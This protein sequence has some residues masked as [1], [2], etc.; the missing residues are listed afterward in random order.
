[1][2]SLRSAIF[3]ALGALFFS[4]T[5]LS[6][7]Y[8]YSSLSRN[9]FEAQEL[10]SISVFHLSCFDSLH[11]VSERLSVKLLIESWWHK[12]ATAMQ[13]T[14]NR[15]GTFL[16]FFS[17]PAT[18]PIRQ[19]FTRYSVL[20]PR[21]RKWGIMNRK[22]DSKKSIMSTNSPVTGGRADT[23]WGVGWGVALL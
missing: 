21:V 18:I 13:S 7:K 17:R 11:K 15:G 9:S 16:L 23:T 4:P 20:S 2:K 1:M 5:S 12:G 19:F 14:T 22:M 6:E 3:A 8:T 10:S